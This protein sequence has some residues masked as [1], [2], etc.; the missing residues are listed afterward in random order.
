[1]FS[2]F[3]QCKCGRIYNP[4]QNKNATMLVRCPVCVME[5]REK[6]EGTQAE[7]KQKFKDESE[8]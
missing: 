4:S 7:Q 8:R 6:H 3:S 1:M 5:E 2:T